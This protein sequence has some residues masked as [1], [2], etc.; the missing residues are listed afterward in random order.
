VSA[1][2]RQEAWRN[3][4]RHT[5]VAADEAPSAD[6]R[7]LLGPARAISAGWSWQLRVAGLQPIRLRI[8]PH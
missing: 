5:A 2:S 4:G 1:T 8:R 7:G 3:R 6:A